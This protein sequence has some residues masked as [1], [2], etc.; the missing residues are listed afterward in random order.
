MFKTIKLVINVEGMK[1]NNCANRITNEL[2]KLPKVKKVTANLK[3][4]TV[5]IKSSEALDEKTIKNEIEKLGYTII[6]N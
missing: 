2:I 3:R 4:K 5:T 1:C 6:A